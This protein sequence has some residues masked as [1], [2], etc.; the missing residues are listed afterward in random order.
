[1]KILGNFPSEI[2]CIKY[3]N[4]AV[5]N[6]VFDVTKKSTK[7]MLVSV[8]F[9]CVNRSFGSPNEHLCIKLLDFNCERNSSIIYTIVLRGYSR[10]ESVITYMHLNGQQFTRFIELPYHRLKN[11]NEIILTRKPN[12]Y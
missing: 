3:N 11:V 6:K 4:T 10:D 1:M 7:N 2:V 8:F 9:E 12:P 5:R